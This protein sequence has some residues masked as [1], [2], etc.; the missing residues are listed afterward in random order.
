MTNAVECT[1][2]H[3]AGGF[4][5][6]DAPGCYSSQGECNVCKGSGELFRCAECEWLY[7][8]G[9]FVDFTFRC[10][11]CEGGDSARTETDPCIRL[12]VE[13]EKR[14]IMKIE[15]GEHAVFDGSLPSFV[16]VAR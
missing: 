12:A 15:C 1:R 11:Y 4:G 16:R 3:G 7:A 6:E 10:K 14:R 9:D 5:H 8:A 13:Q 2:C